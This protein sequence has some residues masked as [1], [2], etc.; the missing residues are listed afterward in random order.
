MLLQ[1]ELSLTLTLIISI[2]RTTPNSSPVPTSHALVGTVAL[3]GSEIVSDNSILQAQVQ[4]GSIL[5]ELSTAIPRD[6]WNSR[7]HKTNT[8]PSS[9]HQLQ[10]LFWSRTAPSQLYSLLVH[11]LADG[12]NS[13]N[14]TGRSPDA[15]EWIACKA[16]PSTLWITSCLETSLSRKKNSP[17]LSRGCSWFAVL[18]MRNN[19]GWGYE[20]QLTLSNPT[21]QI[22]DRLE[23]TC[24]RTHFY[25]A[26]IKLILQ[27]HEIFRGL[28]LSKCNNAMPWRVR[29]HRLLEQI[30]LGSINRYLHLFGIGW[31]I[32]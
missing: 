7:L 32:W 11:Y 15:K 8:P 31:V 17:S 21:C 14:H 27:L 13:R 23:I 28:S 22:F 19:R 29:L 16:I 9:S 2:R 10:A 4:V 3:V 26:S 24:A 25:P 6:L 30:Q 18:D 1:S 20:A 12:L 5:L